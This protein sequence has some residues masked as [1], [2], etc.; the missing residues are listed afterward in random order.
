[1]RTIPKIV[2]KNL[3]NTDP[4]TSAM[5]LL[6]YMIFLADKDGRVRRD[7]Y[8]PE[9]IISI[10]GM[11][12]ISLARAEL[13]LRKK[14]LIEKNPLARYSYAPDEIL[15]TINDYNNIKHGYIEMSTF[16][17]NEFFSLS[18]PAKRLVLRLLM[19]DVTHHSLRLSMET[20]HEWAEVHKKVRKLLIDVLNEILPFFKWEVRGNIVYFYKQGDNS[21][22]HKISKEFNEMCK[23]QIAIKKYKV[24]QYLKDLTALYI[25]RRK[26]GRYVFTKALAFFALQNLS[27]IKNAMAFFNSIAYK[28][29]SRTFFHFT[30]VQ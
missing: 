13:F 27:L 11:S 20:L 16:L 10:T 23:M 22:H 8:V 19:A 29:C 9:D 1:M 5:S 26:V 17:V 7:A 6:I 28:I 15:Y 30:T 2:I 24:H 4:T 25:I 21:S 12:N 18:K 3:L 14:G